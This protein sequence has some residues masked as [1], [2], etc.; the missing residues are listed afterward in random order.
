MRAFSF[1]AASLLKEKLELPT[2]CQRREKQD[3]AQERSKN[4]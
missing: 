3:F 2:Y 1:S 4:D